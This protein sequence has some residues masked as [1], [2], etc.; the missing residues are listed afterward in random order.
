MGSGIYVA[1]A[2]AVAQ[3]TA[4]DVA[5]NNIANATTTG[6]QAARLSFSEALAKARSPDVALVGN[7][8]R[9]VVDGQPGMI[10]QTGNPLDVALDGDGYLAVTTPDG[11]RYTRAGALQ[12]D[13]EGI[14]RTPDGATVRGQ[15]GIPI[16]LPEGTANVTIAEDGAVFGDGEELGRLELVRFDR[17]ALVREG[18]ALFSARPRRSPPSRRRASCKARSRAPTSTSSAASSIW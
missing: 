4:L 13:P 5:A 14:L 7:S 3:S 17:G 9:E 18:G 16:Q 8:T 10:T 2:G 11:V 12:R 1:T 6:F 15:G